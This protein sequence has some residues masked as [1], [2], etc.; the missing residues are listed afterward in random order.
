MDRIEELLSNY[1]GEDTGALARQDSSKKPRII[2]E[3]GSFDDPRALQLI[4][5]AAGDRSEF[6]LARIAAFRVLELKRP[7]APE[8]QRRIADVIARVVKEDPDD[9]VRNYAVMAATYYMIIDDVA[10]QTIRV[11]QTDTENADLRWN[12]FAAIEKM[13]PTAK[14]LNVMRAIRGDSEFQRASE[15]VLIE[16]ARKEAVRT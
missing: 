5:E 4:L 14:G 16:W 15:R 6:D 13:G 11:L 10:D 8:D 12:A 2:E 7:T 9:D 3:L 1:R